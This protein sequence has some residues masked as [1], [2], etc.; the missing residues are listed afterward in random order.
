MKHAP[1][2]RT[3]FLRWTG[4]ESTLKAGIIVAI[5]A[6][7]VFVAW[8]V[9]LVFS[10]AGRAEKADT[11]IRQQQTAITRADLDRKALADG[12]ATANAA[13]KKVGQPPVAVPPPPPGSISS[14]QIDAAVARYCASGLC[15]PAAGKKGDTGP[16]PTPAQIS[17]AVTAYCAAGACAGTN[18]GTGP[19]PSDEQ[20]ASAVA[21]YCA[22]NTCGT[23]G[24]DGT[25][26]PGTYTCPV[27]EVVHGFTVASSG[28]V[29]LD[30]QKAAGPPNNNQGG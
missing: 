28:A 14:A 1:N 15:V 4:K 5:V 10:L 27:G 18:G 19:G 8:L 29:T 2:R 16:A 24:S 25:A 9:L 12:L 23:R 7:V 17:A 22:T 6:L 21:A 20:V 26:T 11:A 30:C 13:L 3:A